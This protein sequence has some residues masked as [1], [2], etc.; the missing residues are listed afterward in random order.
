ML[1]IN[2]A[3]FHTFGGSDDSPLFYL[4]R[5]GY[6]YILRRRESG[7]QAL[8][9]YRIRKLTAAD[10]GNII[11]MLT[12]DGAVYTHDGETMKNTLLKHVTDIVPGVTVRDDEWCVTYRKINGRCDIYNMKLS[13]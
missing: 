10:K 3:S 1:A 11:V 7:C 6:V 13:Q 9:D 2:V 12:M 5:D 4:T 8:T